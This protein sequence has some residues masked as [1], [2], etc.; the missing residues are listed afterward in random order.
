M[1]GSKSGFK[2]KA[3]Y[4]RA[5]FQIGEPVLQSL[6]QSFPSPQS[7]THCFHSPTPNPEIPRRRSHPTGRNLLTAYVRHS[8][9]DYISLHVAVQRR[10][11]SRQKNITKDSDHLLRANSDPIISQL[12]DICPRRAGPLFR[13][14]RVK[15]MANSPPTPSRL[16]RVCSDQKPS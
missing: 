7:S 5:L 13:P 15:I 14:R 8:N 16:Q 11:T 3:P 10:I 4:R 6:F 1:S 12:S 9:G 2:E